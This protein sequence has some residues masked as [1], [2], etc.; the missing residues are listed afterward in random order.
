MHLKPSRWAPTWTPASC[1]PKRLALRV[2]E[3]AN[4]CNEAALIA[5]RR[6]KKF[7]TDQDFTDA[8]DRV[9][10]GLEKKNKNHFARREATVAYQRGRPRHRGLVPRARAT[11]LVKGEPSCPAG[12]AAA[13]GY[14]QYLPKE[15]FL[16]PIPSS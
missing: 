14:A 15:Q 10:G 12:V 11:T 2:A 7:I 8:I 9:I 3:I 4:V 5:A 16:G 1:R 13:L 6:D